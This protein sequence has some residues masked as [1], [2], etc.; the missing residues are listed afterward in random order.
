MPTEPDYPGARPVS[1]RSARGSA[2][3]LVPAGV[4]VLVILA[5]MAVDMGVVYL[6]QRQ[7]ADAVTAAANDAVNAGISDPGFYQQ[8]TVRLDDTKV[9]DVVCAAM[10]AQTT[11]GVEHVALQVAVGPRTVAVAADGQVREVF[12]RA[13]PGLPHARRVHAEA[14][15]AAAAGPGPLDRTV[16]TFHTVSC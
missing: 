5:A 16:S 4:L 10:R 2:L 7:L 6:G 12:G 8:G 9:T 14:A 3:M 1:D 13:V 15:A 11:T